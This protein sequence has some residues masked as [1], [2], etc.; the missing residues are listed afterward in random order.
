MEV[1]VFPELKLI[2]SV[3]PR[4]RA[5]YRTF[6]LL[7]L[8]LWAAS[9]QGTIPDNPVG[10]TFKALLEAFNSGDR[11]QVEAYCQKSD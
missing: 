5:L 9:P 3:T 2:P 8:G 11:P 6:L 1:T 7:M 4:L 10:K